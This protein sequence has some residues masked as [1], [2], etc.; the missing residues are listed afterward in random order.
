MAGQQ[1]T[2][3]TVDAP[4]TRVVA[5]SP[6][7]T[8][9]APL[10]VATTS[11]NIRTPN[12]IRQM[13]LVHQRQTCNNNPFHI[14]FDND[15]NDDT[16]VASNCSPNAPSHILP[17]SVLLVTPATCQAPRKLASPPPIS[18][19]TVQPRLLPTTPPT[20][21]P[22]TPAFIPAIAPPAPYSPI[23]D[24]CPD[25]SHTPLKPPSFTKQRV[26]SL[27]I[28]E[29]DD[30]QDSTPTARPSSLPRCSTQLIS[31]RNPLQYLVSGIISYN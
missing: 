24:L 23:H 11:N 8:T 12:A 9:T 4:T 19:S 10:R 21:V 14:L 6:R 29:P 25:P 20:R 5:P 27:L 15:D 26:H 13:P 30:K 1:A 22:A 2:P 31:N 3:P 17:S 7:V 18:P 28:V 16:V